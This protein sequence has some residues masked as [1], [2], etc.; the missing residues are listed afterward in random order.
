MRRDRR[1]RRRDGAAPRTASPS[2]ARGHS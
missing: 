2:R 1:R